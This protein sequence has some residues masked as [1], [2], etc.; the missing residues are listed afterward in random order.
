M[1]RPDIRELAE[2]LLHDPGRDSLGLGADVEV[3][4]DVIDAVAARFFRAPSEEGLRSWQSLLDAVSEPQADDESR[5]RL[6][7]HRAL[8]RAVS[9]HESG[10]P[11][12]RTSWASSLGEA[13]R[14]S[15]HVEDVIRGLGTLLISA[16]TSL[17]G[18]G[19]PQGQASS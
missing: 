12:A 16:F 6:A 18:S 5:A 4:L 19:S 2:R 17:S 15:A 8:L 3:Q 14:S 13:A 7:A 10:V 11:A 9:S 1:P